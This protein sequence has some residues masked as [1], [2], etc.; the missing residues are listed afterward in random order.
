MILVRGKLE[1]GEDTARLLATEVQPLATLRERL[2]RTVA[3][4]LLVPPH[5]RSTFEALVDLF[6]RHRGD[7]P[8][9]IELELQGRGRPLRVQADVGLVRVKPSER[10]RA[11][12]ED[13]CGAGTV[14]LRT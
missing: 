13:I 7:R 1:K 14:S 11:E 2:T 6:N 5:G 4:R 12:V 3:I 8:V 9:L 10:L